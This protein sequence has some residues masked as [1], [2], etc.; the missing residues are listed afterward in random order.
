MEFPAS[1]GDPVTLR[2]GE[3][4]TILG[5]QRLQVGAEARDMVRLQRGRLAVDELDEAAAEPHW[6]PWPVR[7]AIASTADAIQNP[8]E[9]PPAARGGE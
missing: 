6:R 8:E 9:S 7:D 2:C 3:T 1:I 5:V 4:Y